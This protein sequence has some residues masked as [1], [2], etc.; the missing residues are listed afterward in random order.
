MDSPLEEDAGAAEVDRLLDL[1]AD[2]VERQDVRLGVLRVRAV[3]RAELATVDTDVRVVDVAVHDVG[4]DV[5]VVPPVADLVRRGAELEQPPLREERHRV[6]RGKPLAAERRVQDLFG[7]E[8]H[9]RI[10]P[11]G[12]VRESGRAAGTSPSSAASR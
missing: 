9:S 2:L 4:R 11:A 3:E 7:S 10:V 1:P 12:A 6:G 5:P 8:V